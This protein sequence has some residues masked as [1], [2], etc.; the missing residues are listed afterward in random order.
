MRKFVV[1]MSGYDYND[2]KVSS[3]TELHDYLLNLHNP[4]PFSSQ[5]KTCYLVFIQKVISMIIYGVEHLRLR[6][7]RAY[8]GINLLLIGP[9]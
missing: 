2:P 7:C 4:T 5:G 1:A 8:K 3:H 9:I 6:T